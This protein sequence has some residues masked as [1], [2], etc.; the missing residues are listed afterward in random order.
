MTFAIILSIFAPFLWAMTNHIDK[1]ML[2][3]IDTGKSNIKV[4]LVFSTF[5]SGLIISPLWLIL[6]NFSVGIKP[7]ALICILLA[8]WFCILT[9][10]LYFKAIEEND[11]SFIIVFYQLVPVFSYIF[12][13]LL[14]KETLT[15]RQIIGSLIILLSAIII[16]IEFKEKNNK[17]KLKAL[18]LMTL[19]SLCLYQ[20]QNSI[21]FQLII[22]FLILLLEIVNIILVLFGIKWDSCL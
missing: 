13:F 1:Y 4:L 21:M 3:K 18:I 6:S 8:S 20:E 19:S 9:T 17:K 5:I 16:S 10:T 2:T 14:F 11:A 12:A 15:V 7:I 22:Y